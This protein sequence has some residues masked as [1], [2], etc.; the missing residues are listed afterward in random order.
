MA[1]KHGRRRH[2][3]MEMTDLNTNM[4]IR[5]RSNLPLPLPPYGKKTNNEIHK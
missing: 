5:R 2:I 1:E 4:D 3:M